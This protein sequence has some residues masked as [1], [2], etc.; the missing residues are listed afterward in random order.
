[1]KK[2]IVWFVVSCLMVSALVLASCAPAVSPEEEKPAPPATEKPSKPTTEKPAKP[3]EE[4]VEEKAE[5]VKVRLT[6]LD[7]TVVEKEIEKPRYGGVFKQVFTY[8]PINFDDNLYNVAA[9]STYI[10]TNEQLIQGDWSR[11]PAGTGEAS[12]MYP[13]MPAKEVQ[14]GQL[15]ESWEMPDAN[16]L[17]YHIRKGVHFALDPENEASRL[18]NGREMDAEDVL[19]AFTRA[20]NAPRSYVATAYPWKTHIESITAP[21]NWTVI[22]K[23]VPG[24]T[25]MI[26]EMVS[27]FLKIYPPEVVKKYGDMEDWR[28]SVGTGAFILTDYVHGSVATFIKNPNYWMKDPLMPENTLPYL[29]GLKA[30]IIPDFSTRLAALRT[31]KLDWHGGQGPPAAVAWEDAESLMK[32]NPELKYLEF[33]PDNV[34]I[35]SW[36]IDKPELPFHDIRVR[37]A[38]H[39][40]LDQQA[41]VRDYYGGHAELICFPILPI[42]EYQDIYI[43][44]EKY[45][46][47]VRDLFTYN[48]ERAKSLL[49]EA[50]YPNGFQTEILCTAGSADFLSIIKDY[51]SKVGVDLVLDVKETAAVTSIMINKAHNAMY[52]YYENS[53]KTYK[54]SRQVAFD[55]VP[56][57]A[58]YSMI[59][60]PVINKAYDDMTAV[61]FDKPKRDEIQKEISPYLL[62]Q[63]YTLVLPTPYVYNFWQPWV[64]N[65]S[66]EL[67]V[68]Y[69]GSN[70]D[71]PKYIWVDQDMKEQMIG[72]R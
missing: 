8:D 60:D 12:W 52:L 11:G 68:G 66:G 33:L 65:Y 70:M 58:N 48:P 31:G 30:L 15:A 13:L 36:R 19:F 32:T 53:S 56:A 1:M 45:P 24:K 34:P 18:V 21:D 26:Y 9:V 54:L 71:F 4:V 20:W 3:E 42:A 28:N 50:G 17:V 46:Q 38:L 64:K 14:M 7:G 23:C 35:I 63:A 2:K 51:W 41:I 49:A 55:G 39:M 16:T 47:S 44:L 22:V 69:W 43:P 10:H 25:G 5:M 59:N 6:K 57:A 40:A 62:E 72:V 37:H 27:A 61:Y 67:V 29:D